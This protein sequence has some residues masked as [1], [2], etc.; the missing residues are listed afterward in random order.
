MIDIFAVAGLQK[1]DIPILSDEFLAEVRS[2]E[3]PN[4]AVELLQ[5]LLKGEVAARRGRNVVRARSFA[6]MLDIAIRR[7]Q[8]RSIAAAQVIEELIELAR[9]MREAGNA[10]SNWAC[11]TT[12]SPS[13]TPSKPTTAPYRCSA[14]R[15]CAL[16]P[17]SLFAPSA[18]T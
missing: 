1:P 15:H 14:T 18:P 3:H 16:S 9:E 6:E 5:K 13:M 2:M 12:N 7:Y 8:N 10:G 11:P 17:A 4:L